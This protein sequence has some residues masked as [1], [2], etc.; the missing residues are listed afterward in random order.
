VKR[1]PGKSFLS[2]LFRSAQILLV[3]NQSA[4]IR[5]RLL[6]FSKSSSAAGGSLSEEIEEF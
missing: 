6:S 5:L 1:K 2:K 3:G 4:L